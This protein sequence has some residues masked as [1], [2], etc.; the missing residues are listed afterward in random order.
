MLKPKWCGRPKTEGRHSNCH[1]AVATLP[2]ELAK[3]RDGLCRVE[4]CFVM[5]GGGKRIGR[6][7]VRLRAGAAA[8]GAGAAA[9]RRQ[10]PATDPPPPCAGADA[11]ATASA[12][13]AGAADLRVTPDF[14][15]LVPAAGGSFRPGELAGRA[16]LCVRNI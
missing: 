11:A 15:A 12:A 2:P 3:R 7:C 14:A 13:A 8:V 9:V 6:E 1:G 5:P 10:A 16:G 4:G